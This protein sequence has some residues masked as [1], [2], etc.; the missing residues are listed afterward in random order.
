[1]NAPTTTPNDLVHYLLERGLLTREA[2]IDGGVMVIPA[3]RRNNNFSVVADAGPSYF[4]K[5]ML[6]GAAQAQETLRQ[7]ATLYGIA[8]ATEALAPLR[9]VLPEYHLYDPQRSLII[10]G[11]LRGSR[12]LSELHAQS[13]GAP[14]WA[15]EL[16][17]RALGAV[18]RAGA[19]ALPGLDPASF[20]R[21]TPWALS[22]HQITPTFGQPGSQLQTLL[23]SYPEFGEAL[24]T[25][26]NGWRVNSVIHGDMKFDNCLAVEAGGTRTLKII[27]WELAD[28]GDELWDVAGIVQN[29]LFWSAVSAQA[30]ADGAWSVGMPFET[31]LPAM[32]TFWNAWVAARELPDAEAGVSLERCASY[33]AARLLQSTMEML[34]VSPA[35]SQQVALLLQT[36]LN[37]LRS[38][39]AT[40]RMI[41]AG[42]EAGAHA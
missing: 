13:G 32:R 38:P 10:L 35:M 21:Q 11:Y 36:S 29:Y 27:D 4:V 40:A 34:M 41:A 19:S 23:L 9:E 18:H 3:A 22:L 31:L 42:T 20:K 28:L 24:D 30:T 37:V 17:G 39:G 26:R 6:P 15:A 14:E 5:S 12:T 1:M 7:E 25:M 8:R 2:V 16:T 33:A